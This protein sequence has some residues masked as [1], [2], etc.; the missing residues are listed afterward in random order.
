MWNMLPRG[1]AKLQLLQD[2][3]A[4]EAEAILTATPRNCSSSYLPLPQGRYAFKIAASTDP[5]TALKTFDVVLRPDVFVT[6]LA[7][8]KE[9]KPEIE[10]LDDT[11]DPEKATMGRLIIRQQVKGATVTVTSN[12]SVSSRPL[13]YGETE[14]IENLPLQLVFFRMKATQ[15]NGKVE[16]WSTEVDFRTSRRASL[17]LL[18]DPYGRF[19]A[20]TSADGQGEKNSLSQQ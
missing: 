18:E 20:T 10:M 11:Y 1:S 13:N 6:F 19:R 4:A 15:P 7:Q 16:N 8:E 2:K 14:T 12:V 17:L 9:G 5:K 3:G